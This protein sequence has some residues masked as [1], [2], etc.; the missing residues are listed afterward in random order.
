MLHTKSYN[1]IKLPLVVDSISSTPKKKRVLLVEGEEPGAER[2]LL[3]PV[4][5]HAQIK[6]L[7]SEV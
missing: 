3:L 5:S 1:F 4:F 6:R 7:P 2:K